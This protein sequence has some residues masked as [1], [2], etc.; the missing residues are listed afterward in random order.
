M[1]LNCF[2][3]GDSHG[4][5]VVLGE[6][7]TVKNNIIPFDQ[8]NVELLGDFIWEKKKDVIGSY[9]MN[10]WKVEIKGTQETRKK[11][12]DVKIDIKKELEGVQLDEFKMVKNIFSGAPPEECIHIIVQPLSTTGDSHGFSVVLGERIT[13]KNNIIPFDQF[14]VELLGDFIWEKKKDVIG[15]YNM[16]LWKVEIKGT[17]ETRKKLQD[18]KIDIK[19]ELEGV[20]LD[21]FKMVKNIFSGAPPEECIHIIVQPLSTTG[22]ERINIQS[23]NLDY[24]PRQGYS[25]EGISLTDPDISVRSEIILSLIKDLM[26]KKIILVRSPP[27]SGKTS[28]AQLTEN[29]LVQSQDFLEYRVIRIS[30]LW[31]SAKI[32]GVS[33]IEWIGQCKS[34]PSILIMDEVQKI[35]KGEHVFDETETAMEFWNTIKAN[36]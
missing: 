22:Q 4:F 18:V 8:F 34:I 20:Q 15:S 17:Q 21:E 19:K 32:I 30:M 13:V 33:W 9:N 12:Q 1:I 10:L 7:I 16:N 36:L 2:V 24:L 29:Y 23:F 28:L 11:L 35:Y 31:A 27:C 3:L 14:N 6:R 25:I 26:Q 5:S